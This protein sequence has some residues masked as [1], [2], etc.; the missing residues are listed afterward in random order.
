MPIRRALTTR[1]GGASSGPFRS[2]NLAASVGDDAA[3]VRANKRRLADSLGLSPDRLVWMD[4]IHGTTVAAVTEPVTAALPA[5]DG[6]VTS[7]PGL[8]LVVRVADCVPVLLADERA[9]V[10]GVAHAGRPGAR[11]GIGPAV[12]SAMVGLGA[13]PQDIDVLLG[14]AICGRCYE[15]PPAMQADVEA[16]LPGS[17]CRTAI[18][19]TGLDIARGLE[20]QLL[21]LGV[22]RVV[23]DSRCTAE[24]PALYSYRRDGVTGR[25]AGIA[26]IE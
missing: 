3:A 24:D 6:A 17:A 21:S 12:V 9:G 23:T 16:H 20:A 14:P 5:T 7:V 26:W 10:A 13:H 18:G 22:G 4:Q 25:H 19:T 11:A 15:V 1:A 2:F 8:A